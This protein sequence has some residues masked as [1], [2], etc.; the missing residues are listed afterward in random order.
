[1]RF[2]RRVDLKHMGLEALVPQAIDPCAKTLLI[3]Q[4]ADHD[5]QPGPRRT[6]GASP[7]ASS[8]RVASRSTCQGERAG[9][10]SL[11]EVLPA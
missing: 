5:D 1:M 4:V 7:V 10:D 6:A 3:K 8:V 2:G 11:A 9:S